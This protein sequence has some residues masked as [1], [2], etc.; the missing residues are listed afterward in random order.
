MEP[1]PLIHAPCIFVASADLGV[2][3]TLI[4]LPGGDDEAGSSRSVPTTPIQTLA[5]GN[6]TYHSPPYRISKRKFVWVGARCQKNNLGTFLATFCK[7]WWLNVNVIFV[8]INKT[9]TFIL[10]LKVSVAEASP[11]LAEAI[12]RPESTVTPSGADGVQTSSAVRPSSRGT[13][14]AGISQQR[15]NLNL[16]KP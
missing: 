4:Y 11:S 15:W 12:P 10:F 7:N 14:E 8:M 9:S 1:H 6:N 2:D 16:F 5:P 3:D 13:D